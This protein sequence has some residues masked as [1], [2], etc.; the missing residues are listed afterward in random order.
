M[1]HFKRIEADIDLDKIRQ[2]INTIKALNDKDKKTLLV[3][4][5]D[6][7]G[8]GAVEIAREMSDLCDYFGVAAIDEGVELRNSGITKPIL[9]LGY[10]DEDDYETAIEYDIT[11]A[12]FNK[13]C[14]KA[15]SD[16]AISMGKKAKVHIKA[17]S[18]MSR[19]GFQ[20]D[21]DGVKEALSLL[22]MEGLDIESVSIH[23]K[24]SLNDFFIYNLLLKP[25]SNSLNLPNVPFDNNILLNFF[26]SN[27]DTTNLIFSDFILNLY[28]NNTKTIA[29]IQKKYIKKYIK[30]FIK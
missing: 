28:S 27:L 8:H 23:N 16:K 9:I 14:C 1:S 12:V 15:L 19:I 10:T 22:S 6:A 13:E 26:D 3:V 30:S 5:A 18:G 2:N 20:C 25:T 4:K 11:Q 24:K 29:D 21:E 7:Y 17:D